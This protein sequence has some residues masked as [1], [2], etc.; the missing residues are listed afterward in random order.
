MFLNILKHDVA[1]LVLRAGL[2]VIF[3]YHGSE[4]ALSAQAGWGTT[5]NPDPQ[6]P[7]ALQAMVAWGEFAGG[8]ALLMGFLSRLAALGIAVIMAGAI[9][10][11]HGPKGFGLQH[12]GFEYNY[13][14]I[15]MCLAI[16]CTGAGRY[17][18]DYLLWRRRAAAAAAR[19]PT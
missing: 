17:S 5:W 1:P 3:L 7:A 2:G 13:A 12:G 8:A 15:M 16:M 18:V 14:L 6:M 19:Q 9:V 4:K 11:V 10:T